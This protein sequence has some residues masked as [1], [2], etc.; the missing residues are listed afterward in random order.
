MIDRQVGGPDGE[1]TRFPDWPRILGELAT[2]S[3]CV[4]KFRMESVTDPERLG[5]IKMAAL[6]T[7]RPQHVVAIHRGWL[8]RV[9]LYDNE[10]Q[11]RLQGTYSEPTLHQLRERGGHVVAVTERASPLANAPRAEPTRVGEIRRA[12]REARG[13]GTQG[14]GDQDHA[15]A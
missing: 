3:D 1:D 4:V 10:S 6:Y 14:D 5:H 12:R 8:G 11:E 13:L 7:L 9:R 15:L 2:V